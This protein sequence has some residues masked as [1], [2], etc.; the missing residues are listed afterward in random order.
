MNES[1]H[2]SRQQPTANL[3]TG[4]KRETV[5]CSKMIKPR[6]W[7]TTDQ[8]YTYIGLYIGSING[9]FYEFKTR[10]PFYNRLL[11]HIYFFILLHS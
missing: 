4:I 9:S 5:V 1:K 6:S 10:L 3:K 7:F 11:Y 2:G 8:A